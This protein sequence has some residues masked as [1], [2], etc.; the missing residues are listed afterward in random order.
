[1][2]L[3][4]VKIRNSLKL[5][6]SK[7]YLPFW[8]RLVRCLWNEAGFRFRLEFLFFPL[9]Y[10]DLSMDCT[11]AVVTD[12]PSISCLYFSLLGWLLGTWPLSIFKY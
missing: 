12:F 9:K 8:I 4:D 7:D 2:L 1:M 5:E 10:E 6:I 3:N 11:V